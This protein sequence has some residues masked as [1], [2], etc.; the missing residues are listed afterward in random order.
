MPMPKINCPHCGAEITDIYA[1]CPKCKSKIT[2][3]ERRIARADYAAGKPYDPMTKCISCGKEVSKLADSCPNCGRRLREP[4][5]SKS[6]GSNG[7]T[8]FLVV[9]LAIIFAVWL[10]P[11]IF[12]MTVTVT[13]IK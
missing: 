9:V 3:E 7:F 13:P 5:Q 10:L 4:A 2:N 6:N 8:I 12:T 1:I 11:Q